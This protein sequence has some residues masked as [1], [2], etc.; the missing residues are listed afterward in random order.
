M[1]RT[2]LYVRTNVSFEKI[3]ITPKWILDLFWVVYIVNLQL[4][5]EKD[6]NHNQNHFITHVYL[7]RYGSHVTRLRPRPYVYLFII[8]VWFSHNFVCSPKTLIVLCFFLFI[9]DNCN[10]QVSHYLKVDKKKKPIKIS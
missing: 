10:V 8:L 4:N 7:C 6:M 3:Y 9:K 1:Q 2:K 5:E